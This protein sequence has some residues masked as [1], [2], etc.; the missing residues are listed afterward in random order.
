MTDPVVAAG[1]DTG[2]IHRA[3]DASI[4]TA[5]TGYQLQLLRAT[6]AMFADDERTPGHLAADLVSLRRYQLG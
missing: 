4:Q 2:S 6:E 5:G 1:R 3:I